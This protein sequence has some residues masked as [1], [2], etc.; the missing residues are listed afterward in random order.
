MHRRLL[1]VC[2]YRYVHTYHMYLLQLIY[3]AYFQLDAHCDF[4]SAFSYHTCTG[5][6]T[7]GIV[8]YCIVLDP[9]GFMITI[10]GKVTSI[11]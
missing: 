5:I 10:V 7:N 11:E 1:S 4:A 9:C 3:I 6:N 2:V 8:L